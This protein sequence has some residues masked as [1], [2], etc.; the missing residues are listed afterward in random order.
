M[1]GNFPSNVISHK[2]CENSITV[3]LYLLPVHL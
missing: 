1:N 3:S 2:F